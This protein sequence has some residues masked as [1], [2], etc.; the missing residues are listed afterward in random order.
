MA[1]CA[2][3][4]LCLAHIHPLVVAAVRT[5]AL[6]GTSYARLPRGGDRRGEGQGVVCAYSGLHLVALAVLLQT[7]GFLAVAAA[8]VP[9][10]KL[11][12]SH[13][14]DL[15]PE[16]LRVPASTR[17]RRG[18]IGAEEEGGQQ[19]SVPLTVLAWHRW[20]TCAYRHS[21]DCYDTPRSC[22]RSSIAPTRSIRSRASDSAN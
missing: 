9:A 20:R 22:R 7:T 17:G 8:V 6:N 15:W 16:R 1:E 19:M 11:R 21:R 3:R 12:L 14:V 2:W 13:V 10:H 5:F 4:E 18:A